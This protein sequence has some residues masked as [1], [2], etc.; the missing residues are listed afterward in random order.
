MPVLI[1]V[2]LVS[3]VVTALLWGRQR[4][5]RRDA[6]IRSYRDTLRLF[7]VFAAGQCRRGVTQLTFD[8]LGF[9]RVLAVLRD[10]E[11]TGRNA[12]ATR[13]QRLAGLHTFYEYVG[14]RL[15]EPAATKT[16]KRKPVWHDDADLQLAGAGPASRLIDVIQACRP[17]SQAL[18]DTPTDWTKARENDAA[19]A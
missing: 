11:Q 2:C 12:I 13:N 19:L 10:L 4:A 6:Y 7:P 15:S 18:G 8:D 3:L 17:C 9:E 14:R 1:V 5:L 16:P